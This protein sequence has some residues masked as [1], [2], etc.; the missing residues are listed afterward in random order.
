MD[1]FE[2]FFFFRFFNYFILTKF[3]RQDEPL[4]GFGAG[5]LSKEDSIVSTVF[6]GKTSWLE[7]LSRSA[8]ESFENSLD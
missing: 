1:I 7:P 3:R 4:G 5:R 8:L 2:D 6:A